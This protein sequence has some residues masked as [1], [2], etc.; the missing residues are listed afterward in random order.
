MTRALST[1]AIALSGKLEQFNPMFLEDPIRPDNFDAMAQVASMSRIPIA[2]GERIH[3]IFEF[4]MLLERKACHYVRASICLC[5]GI[6][7]AM[8]IAALA[9]SHHCSLVPHNPLSPVATNVELQLCTAIDNLAIAEYPSPYVRSTQDMFMNNDNKN[10]CMKDMVNHIPDV[11]DGYIEIPTGPGIGIE[12]IP[13][14]EDK[15]PFQTHKI[16]TRLYE[17]GSICDQ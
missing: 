15:F 5:G 2:T 12:L 8:K 4:Q 14:V 16:N 7:G 1:L 9:E 6:T 10:L 13:D 3:N 11:K 17:D